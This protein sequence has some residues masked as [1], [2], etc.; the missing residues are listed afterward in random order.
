MNKLP[1]YF[2][3]QCGAGGSGATVELKIKPEPPVDVSAFSI[4]YKDGLEKAVVTEMRPAG[5]D[6]TI[7]LASVA[8]GV[9]GSSFTSGLQKLIKTQFQATSKSEVII[10]VKLPA[11]V[12]CNDGDIQVA[13]HS[14]RKAA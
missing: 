7:I 10:K 12:T 14:E 1:Y 13:Y 8:L 6:G 4:A 3:A 2:G 5:S 11:G 9:I